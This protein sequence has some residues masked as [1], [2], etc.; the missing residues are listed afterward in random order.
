MDARLQYLLVHCET[1]VGYMYIA[2]HVGDS[3]VHVEKRL[4]TEAYVQ[5]E[6]NIVH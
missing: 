2:T 3:E 4:A 5:L 1:E 6:R